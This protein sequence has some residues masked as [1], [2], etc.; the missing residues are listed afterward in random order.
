MVYYRIRPGAAMLWLPAVSAAGGADRAWRGLV[1]LGAER[2][3]PRRA[4]RGAVSGAVLDVRFA[5]GVSE[6]AGAGRNGAGST[7]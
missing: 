6:F 1:A 5:G 4:L 7:A 2:D 3:L